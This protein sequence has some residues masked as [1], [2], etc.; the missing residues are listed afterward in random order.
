MSLEPTRAKPAPAADDGHVVLEEDRRWL[1][2]GFALAG[3][4]CLAV[5]LIIAFVA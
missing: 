2:I 4:L 1:F 3:V 5:A